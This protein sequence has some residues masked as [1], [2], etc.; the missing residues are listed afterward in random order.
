MLSRSLRSKGRK[1][2]SPS[3]RHKSIRHRP[4]RRLGTR[5]LRKLP[6]SL[7][8][9]VIFALSL[10]L[11][12][13]LFTWEPAQP[14][15]PVSQLTA[16]NKLVQQI[17]QLL[18][19]DEP[20]KQ[21]A[22][23]DLLDQEVQGAVQLLY[24]D[25]QVKQSQVSL[26]D[27]PPHQVFQPLDDSQI[28]LTLP[29][30]LDKVRGLLVVRQKVPP[31]PPPDWLAAMLLSGAI[32]V[33]SI[34]LVLWLKTSNTM[35]QIDLLCRQ[36]LRYRRENETQEM[37]FPTTSRRP[38]ELELRVAVLQDLW[39]KF[40][41]VQ[42]ELT[43]NVEAL[44]QSKQQLENTIEDL[45][46]AKQQEQRLIELGYAVAEFGHDIGNAN[47]S[48][49][50]YSS[51]VLQQLDKPTLEPME[52]AR[53]L[54]HIRKIEL[55]SKNV[56]GLTED[57]LEF[58]RGK[59]QLNKTQHQVEDFITQLE[60]YLGFA[61]DMD[62][63]Y[64]YPK[65]IHARLEFD[66]RK[67]SRVLINLVKNAWEKLREQEGGS[68]T[69]MLHQ[70]RRNL[71]IRVRD[72]GAPIPTQVLPVIFHSFQTEGKEKGT[73]LGLAISKKMVEAHGGEIRAENLEAGGVQFE[74]WLPD[75]YQTTSTNSPAGSDETLPQAANY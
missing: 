14:S 38:N 13:A 36:F 46:K 72:N 60:V 29:V 34:A 66:G 3:Q 71:L 27:L 21:L 35:G 24:L 49:M 73:G 17:N 12:L 59:M 9:A 69:V 7:L 68:I 47:G 23:Q 43:E 19:Q 62:I 74:I 54:V 25:R 53:A 51:L 6:L 1:L 8:A 41:N 22:I 65:N 45:R 20:T 33:A 52:V 63:Q 67:I 57:I 48:I 50:S 61:E 16:L 26:P 15:L 10:S 37:E 42:M 44:E 18:G 32:A 2:L 39:M 40:Q 31:L 56:A 70:E 4:E 55:A 58:A 64:K 75:A 5:R 11:Q 28:L 30:G